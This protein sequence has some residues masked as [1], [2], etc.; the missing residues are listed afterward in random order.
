MAS[1][2]PVS[3]GIPVID[4]ANLVQSIMQAIEMVAQTAKQ[5]EEYSLQLQQY[6]NMLRNTLAPAV[7][8]WDQATRTMDSL[9]TSIDTLAFY[10]TQ[11][12]SIDAYLRKYQ[13]VAF[14]RASPCFT[15][16]GC[17]AAQRAAMKD[18]ERLG[19][20]A[21]KKARDGLFAALDRQQNNMEA[22]ATRLERLQNAAQGATGQL[23]AMQFA[24]QIASQQ[25]NQLLQIR[26]ILLAHQ[27]ADVTRMAALADK[28]A[29]RAAAVDQ[30]R[31]GVFRV[32]GRR[33]W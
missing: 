25:A 5:I 33:T 30:L 4:G 28:E 13:D 7:Y 14:Y 23:Q 20:E 29:K 21:Q 16:T 1:P 26:A 15:A 22:D 17:T 8:I 24:S 6:E 3:A 31:L 19:S 12:G 11:L 2:A 18:S 27:N 9:R 32:S 10:K